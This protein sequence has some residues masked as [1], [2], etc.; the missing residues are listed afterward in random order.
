[1]QKVNPYKHSNIEIKWQ[2]KWISQK[3][4]SPNLKEAA[5][6]YYN[7]M[8]FPYPSAEGL[9]VGNMYA[10]TGAD[11]FGRFMRMKGYDVFEPVGL[12]G[13][14]IHS[15]NYA[16]KLGEHP[17]KLAKKTQE[18]FYKQLHLI[19]NGYDWDKTLET[20]DPNYYRW[21]QWIFV[22]MFK[23]GLAY[24]AKAPVNWCPSCK[25]VLSD[26]QVISGECERCGS[27]VEIKQLEQ[28]FFRLATGIRPSGEAYPDALLRNLDEIDWSQ[29]VKVAQ[30]NWIGRSEGAQVKFKIAGSKSEI[31]V[32]TTRPDTLNAATFLVLSPVSDWVKKLTTKDNH[33]KVSEYIKE[34]Q[35]SQKRHKGNKKTGEFTGSYV[36]NPLTKIKIQVWVSD[37]VIA[38][39]GE[40]A[41]MGVPAHDER[42]RE[43]AEVFDLELDNKKPDPTLWDRIEEEGWGKKA[44]T[45]HIRDWLVSRQRYWG[46]PIPMIYCE[47]CAKRDKGEQ[48]QMPGWYT[49]P[50]S[51]LPVEL[52]FIEDYRPRGTG[53]SPL[54]SDPKFFKVTCPSCGQG[55][56]RET[57]VSDTFLDSAWYFLRY[58]SLGN[59]G[60]AWDPKL[61]RKWFPVDMYIGGPEHAVLHL[62][63]ARFMAMVFKDLGLTHFEEPFDR[64]YAH[65]HIIKEGA[66]MS[67]THGNIVVP[68]DYIEKYGADTLRTYLMFLGPFD[69]GGDFR[70]TGIEGMHR[71]IQRVWRLFQDFSDVVLVKKEDAKKLTIK[72]HQTIKKVSEDL[73]DLRYNTAIS[74]IMELVNL[75][76]EMAEGEIKRGGKAPSPQWKDSLRVLALIMAPF[77]PHMAEELWVNVLGQKFSIH[78]AAWPTWDEEFVK[79][80]EDTIPVQVDGKLR[81]QITVSSQKSAFQDEVQ[82][83]AEA[84]KKVSKWISGVKIKKVIFVPGRLINFVTS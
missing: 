26:E 4:F 15:E 24:R 62:M 29:K 42:D 3:I 53:V 19:G 82:K 67:K 65:G 40:G 75:L 50:E 27:K 51:D 57:D 10:F 58:P 83:L 81:G 69:Q 48:K 43:F 84:D 80:E 34:S 7:L 59:N 28:W 25:T 63:Y 64:F 79:S 66:K 45:Y 76:R 55:A 6:P 61:T 38:S 33:Q 78:K 72:T 11:I 17:L 47:H 12:D 49:V 44:V 8:M 52:P 37:Y 2:K 5:K 46:P 70:D 16:L 77:A 9:H 35:S 14:G 21:T 32:F 41:I 36:V 71:F 73:E 74:A 39:Y 22:K 13:F 18:R 56:S 23:A 31:S 60:L 54:A 68:D 1:M 30:R 20:Y